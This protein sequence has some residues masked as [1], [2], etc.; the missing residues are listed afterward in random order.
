MLITH[1][2][3]CKR[4]CDF[5]QAHL[6]APAGAVALS[7]VFTHFTKLDTTNRA[8]LA[9]AAIDRRLSHGRRILDASP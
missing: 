3:R 9:A 6:S 1:S 4:R 7:G 2:R 5:V 8:Q